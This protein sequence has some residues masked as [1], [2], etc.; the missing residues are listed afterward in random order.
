MKAFLRAV[1]D[2]N[3]AIENGKWTDTP[4]ANDL[5]GIVAR[6]L[7]LKPEQIRAAFPHAVDPDGRVNLDSMRKD[8]QFFR[9]IGE[10][11]TELKDLLN[12]KE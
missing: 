7:E 6:R 4:K 10:F 3:D 9:D 12:A 1:R 11:M 2:Y 5:I 8:L